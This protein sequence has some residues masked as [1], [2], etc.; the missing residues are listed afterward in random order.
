VRAVLTPQQQ[1]IFDRLRPALGPSLHGPPPEGP[2]P[3]A[4]PRHGGPPQG[5]SR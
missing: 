5:P 1:E 3:D 4:P 2:R